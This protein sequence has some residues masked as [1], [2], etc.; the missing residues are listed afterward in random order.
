M[1]G[2]PAI[3][4]LIPKLN[5]DVRLQKPPLTYWMSAAAFKIGGVGEGVGRVPTVILGWLTLAVVYC[6]ARWLF[7]ARCGLLSAACLLGS[8]YFA[9]HTR[10]AET[11]VPATLFVTLAIYALWRGSE[12]AGR[13]WIGWMHLAGFAIGMSVMSKGAPGAF[14][15]VF[16]IGYSLVERSARPIK[17]FILSGAILTISIIATPWFLFAGFHQG[18]HVF[19][20]ELRTVES[21]ADHGAPI[22]QYVPWLIVGAL[23]WSPLALV[24]VFNASRA[25]KTDA[26]LRGL[27]V[28]LGAIALPLCFTGNKQSHYLIPLM[29][30]LM[31][32]TGWMLDR[33][34]IRALT[35][36]TIVCAIALPPIVTLVV[37]RFSDEHAR[38]TAEFVQ[39]HFDDQPLCFF[40][41]N[42]SVP[43]C[44]NLRRSI[45]FANDD[46]E[47]T[48]FLT[49]N[50]KLIVMTISK[51]KR[52]TSAPVENLQKLPDEGRWEDQVWQFYRLVDAPRQ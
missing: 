23:P 22:Y 26:Q 48:Q 31:I 2:R 39:K 45:P 12:I 44:F 8:Y 24:A 46:A 10:L 29:P 28:W 5:R 35:I 38:V 36:A 17:R 6:A 18:W 49:A 25:A 52:P 16:L 27:L 32:L 47:L 7:S 43:L 42:A 21:G 15:L 4:W 20:S 34:N 50:P 51:D 40:G 9:R 1:I 3:D 37:P 14:A 41:Q 30:V 11:D 19:V 13:S 33:W